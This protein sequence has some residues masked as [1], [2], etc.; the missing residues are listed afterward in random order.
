MLS[1]WLSVQAFA[2]I[3]LNTG[4]SYQLLA[5]CTEKSLMTEVNKQ[6]YKIFR[7][8][9]LNLQSLN[10]GC[11]GMAG[12]FGHEKANQAL[13]AELYQM[14]WQSKVQQFPDTLLATGFSCRSQ[15]KRF[16]KVHVK[17]PIQVIA[18][19]TK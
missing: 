16:D 14:S 19:L 4:N 5:H 1:E 17:H 2:N 6:W 15:I 9:G 13:S 18:Q 3:S 7:S 11:C 12:T 8:L 10:A